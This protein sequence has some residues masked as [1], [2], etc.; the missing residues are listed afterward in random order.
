M[1]E[2]NDY[3]IHFVGLGGTGANVIE[4]FFKHK[5]T[6]SFLAKPGIKVSCLAIDVA[7]HDLASLRKTYEKFSAELEE[8]NIASDKVSFTA[9]AVKFPTPEAMFDF[10]SGL[11]DFL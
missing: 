5:N 3:S 11:P 4:A 9:K 1:S 10:I 8:R 7:D 6:H 2:P